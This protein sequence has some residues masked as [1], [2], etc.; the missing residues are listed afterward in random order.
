MFVRPPL[1]WVSSALQS[2]LFERRS[3]ETA[4][5]H[6]A[7]IHAHTACSYSINTC[8]Y[9]MLIQHTYMLLHAHTAYIHAAVWHTAYIHA[10]VWHTAYIHAAV[11]H[12]AYIHAAVWH[13]AYIHAGCKMLSPMPVAA[14]VAS[15]VNSMRRVS[16]ATSAWYSPLQGQQRVRQQ[17]VVVSVL[18]VLLVYIKHDESAAP[19]QPANRHCRGGSRGWACSR[20][21]QLPHLVMLVLGSFAAVLDHVPT[22]AQRAMSA[23]PIHH[24]HCYG[25]L[26]KRDTH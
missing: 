22:H 20:V 17:S 10:A 12:T 18:L 21:L 14:D 24:H 19:P 11:W 7:Y 16:S 26:Y 6:T 13:T 5:W 4:V 25:V 15:I 2:A 23:K 8:S 1:F 3:S 9:S